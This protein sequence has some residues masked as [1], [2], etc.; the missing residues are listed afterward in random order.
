MSVFMY[1]VYLDDVYVKA[2][3][4]RSDALTCASGIKVWLDK[5]GLDTDIVHIEEE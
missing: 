2:F 5:V 1:C 4:N 3:V